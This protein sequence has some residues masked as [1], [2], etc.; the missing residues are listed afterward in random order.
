MLLKKLYK[1]EYLRKILKKILPSIS[2]SQKFYRGKIYLDMKE[3]SW[4]W[5]GKHTY[6]TFDRTIQDF[7]L[8]KSKE[9][10]I[11]IDIGA[12]IG[13]MT[14]CVLL[15]NN[16]ISAVSVEPNKRAVKLLNQSLKKNNLVHRCKVINGAVGTQ[17]GTI[18]FDV[19]GSV[20]GHIAKNAK[21]KVKMISF[22]DLLNEYKEKKCLVKIDIEGY[23]VEILP[24]LKNL[25]GIS[26][27]SF[28]IEIHSQNLCEL[29]NPLLVFNILSDLNAKIQDFN[30]NKI[31]K[32]DDTKIT[33]LI[34]TF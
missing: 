4:A 14:L 21:L 22:L 28:I 19:T 18:G 13:V 12:N 3:H 2:I 23:E 30:G 33:N 6:E 31:E 1:I 7:I 16:N 11:F 10:E 25:S 34:V 26:N 29:G 9:N 24:L 27:F 17:E 15:Q 32:I 20:T 8:E 5:S